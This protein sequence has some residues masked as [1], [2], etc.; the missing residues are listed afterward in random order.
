MKTVFNCD[1]TRSYWNRKD[2]TVWVGCT[3]YQAL[4]NAKYR[5][6][7]FKIPIAIPIFHHKVI[8]YSVIYKYQKLA[9][10]LDHDNRTPYWDLLRQVYLEIVHDLR[11]KSWLDKEDEED[12][13]KLSWAL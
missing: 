12:F 4:K 2:K 8:D 13:N 11:T 3:S 7:A 1:T 10:Q 5:P 6:E 9:D